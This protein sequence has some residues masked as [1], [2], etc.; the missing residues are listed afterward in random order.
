M[1]DIQARLQSSLS[2]ARVL[3]VLTDFGPGRTDAWPMVAPGTFTV[4]DQGEG[5]ADVTVG[6]R[7]AWERLR[8]VWDATTGTVTAVTTDSNIWANGSR[9]EYRLAPAG[10]GTQVDIRLTRNWSVQR[11]PLVS[12]AGDGEAHIG[13]PCLVP[14]NGVPHVVYN[15]PTR[16]YVPRVGTNFTEE[17]HLGVLHSPRSTFPD[18]GRVSSVV[19][20]QS[21]GTV[22]M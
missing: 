9:W 8:Y 18:Y 2:P 5:W 21:G 11:T 19:F 3:H 1:P 6:N 14:K 15:S 4:H 10:A 20:A 12:P 17:T 22:Y 13:N 7:G 16:V